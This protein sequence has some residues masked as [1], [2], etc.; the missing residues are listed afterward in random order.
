MT[1][2]KFEGLG[3]AVQVL[4]FWKTGASLSLSLS[5]EISDGSTESWMKGWIPMMILF[6]SPPE[7]NPLPD[8]VV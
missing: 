3:I 1:S 7:S 4:G 5:P 8:K 6:M 2:L